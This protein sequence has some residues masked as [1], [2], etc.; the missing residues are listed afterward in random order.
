MH[1]NEHAARNVTLDTCHALQFHLA[2]HRN[3]VSRSVIIWQGS[4]ADLRL[5]GRE[6]LRDVR[7]GDE[8]IYQG[9][10]ERVVSVEIYR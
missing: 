3:E 6:R 4:R 10:P 1:L 7:P 8:V 5:V 9:R 2:P